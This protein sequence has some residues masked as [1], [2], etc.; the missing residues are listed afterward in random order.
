MKQVQIFLLL[1]LTST[2]IFA[3]SYVGG[4]HLNTSPDA[5]SAGMGNT[6]VAT[7]PDEFSQFWNPAKLVLI[8]NNYAGSLSYTPPMSN[9]VGRG[10]YA[11][12][13]KQI[14]QNLAVGMSINYLSNGSINLRDEIGTN[15][16]TFSPNEFG[17]DISVS[18][19]FTHEFSMG[20]T[21]RYIKSDMFEYTYNGA[22]QSASTLAIDVGAL[23]KHMLAASSLSFGVVLSNLGGKL[24]YGNDT[25]K[26]LPA[27]LRMGVNYDTGGDNP[28]NI[29]LEFNKLLVPNTSNAVVDASVLSGMISSF[30]AS[31]GGIKNFSVGLGSEYT[32]AGQFMLRS[33]LNFRNTEIGNLSFGTVGFGFIANKLRFNMS[34]IIPINN[35]Q[36]LT[37]NRFKL[38]LGMMF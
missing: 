30:G 28:F 15:T 31:N 22:I 36:Y 6:G 19:K 3:Q 32:F 8:Q 24:N 16:G 13:Y 18:K 33:G 12:G 38:S 21:A 34:Y 37:N 2:S 14:H 20:Y 26:F 23:Y 5:R 29:G 35:Q 1:I 27:N 25:Q 9:G 10:A 11:T 7:S 17:I 4:Q